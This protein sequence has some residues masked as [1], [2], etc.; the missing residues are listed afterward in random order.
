MLK[1]VRFD[2]RNPVEW[3]EY[4]NLFSAFLEEVCDDDEFHE[5]I[6]DLHDEILNSQM[7]EQTQQEHNPYFV[8][9]IV[10]GE[11]CVGLIAYSYNEKCFLGFINNFYVCPEKRSTGIGSTVL[12]MV[13]T[14]LL[15]LGAKQVDLIPVEK[16]K[17]FYVRNGFVQTRTTNDGKQVFGKRIKE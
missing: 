10:L 9:R 6:A 14:H 4:Y 17:P 11:E 2:L 12:R 8:M 7:I 16:A 13:E 5:E 15:K 3:D 1:L